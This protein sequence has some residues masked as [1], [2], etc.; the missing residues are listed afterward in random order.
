MN[1]KSSSPKKLILIDGH[2]L[3]HRAFH[4]LP[5]LTSP[6]GVVT[7]A[8]YGFAAIL[9]K[10]LKDF[11]PEYVV[12][13][14]DLAAPTFR[15]EEFAD[16]KAHREKA[17]DELYAQIPMVKE[18][19]TAFGIP[20]YEK[21]GFEADD[22]I[23]S[24]AIKANKEKHLQVIIMT[25]DLDTLQL[26]KD[27]EIVVCTLKKGV[28]DTIIYNE[29]AVR[30][31]YGLAPSQL[32]DFKGL[33]GDPSDNIPGVPGIGEKT[34]STLMQAFGTLEKL[35]EA[36]ENGTEHKLLTAKLRQKLIDN[37]D[38][39]LFSKRLATI[40]LDVPNTLSL[41]EASWQGHA[42]REALETFF[43]ELGMTS[44]IKRLPEAFGEVVPTQPS[45]LTADPE[46][47]SEPKETTPRKVIQKD[48]TI[49]YDL[50][51]LVK[52]G[53]ISG[54]LFDIRI[55]A[56][57]IAPDARDYDF[58][59]LFSHYL[60]RQAPTHPSDA[61]MIKL[62]DTLWDEMKQRDLL[63]VFEDIEMPL[64]AV[65]AAM[66]NRG[67]TV[68]TKA[69]EKLLKK[70]NET[71]AE[72][73]EKIYG[74]AG[75]PF[76]INSPAQLGEILFEKLALKGKVRKTGGGAPSTAAP[77]L[78]KLREEHPIVDLILEYRELQKLKTTYIEPF[79]HL[80]GPD[81]RIRTTYNQTGAATGR[82][83]S[84]DPNLQNIPI[85]TELGQ[86]FRAAFVAPKGYKLVAFDYTQ[87]ELRIVAHL[88]QDQTMIDVFRRGEDIHTRT[89][90]KI[91]KVS[92]EN[93][94]KD[95][96]RTA[97]VLNFGIIYGMGQNGFARASGVGRN[98]ARAFIDAYFQE[99]KGVAQ[100]MEDTKHLAT[101]QGF[102]A[103]LF[104]RRRPLP[105]I[106]STMPMLRAQA[107]RMAINHPV[108]GTEADLIKLAMIA[109]DEV[110]TKQDW[111][112]DVSMLLQ[113]HD[114]LV[115]EVKDTVVSKAAPLIKE[116][117]EKV[118]VLDVPLTVDAKAGDNW[119]DME[120]LSL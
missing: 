62:K 120:K 89:A 114:E 111:G 68:N 97:K 66:E 88:A 13:T 10:I 49:G 108:Q 113:V 52:K 116:A 31:R 84:Q 104:G 112:D 96:R 22:M 90:A 72:L 16:Y 12:A 81:K 32:V 109:V 33:K 34:A 37:K 51:P 39:A 80:V 24:L 47:A 7:N 17:P 46:P 100:Y 25:G 45:L 70:G 8:V 98:E 60:G 103:T 20:I 110:T 119:S 56:W 48:L 106:T 2:A 107:E 61:D 78:E 18:M 99:F 75:G 93:V 54:K 65:L 38:M 36:V 69:I 92:P 91:F 74:H 50:K 101:K 67:I 35:Y 21:E 63:R 3:V 11:K 6:K 42:K 40:I 53:E 71:L 29:D 58:A 76:N 43:K 5:P 82:L 27:N 94:T 59:T 15:H 55:A 30:E 87:L 79:P 105:E 77:E 83:A 28:S 85:R 4:A 14:F 115:F 102:V 19:L 23:G 41:E 86:Q 44:L 57:L 118:F 95:M 73:E 117:M 64:I 26:V 1:A 9:M